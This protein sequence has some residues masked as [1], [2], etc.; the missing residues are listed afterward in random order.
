[1]STVRPGITLG[2]CGVFPSLV[3]TFFAVGLRFHQGSWGSVTTA[4]ELEKA[5][6]VPNLKPLLTRL[7]RQAQVQRV[8][9]GGSLVYVAVEPARGQ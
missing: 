2:N 8:E 6:Q 4:S 9:V 1:L 5:L 7:A 3:A